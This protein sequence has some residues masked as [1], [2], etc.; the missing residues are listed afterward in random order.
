[1]NYLPIK[2]LYIELTHSCNQHCNHCYLDGGLHHDITEMT[3][4][5][6]K[7]IIKEFKDQGGRYLIIT[8]GEPIM[9]NDIFEI[10]YYIEELEIPFS[11]ASNSL[12]MNESRLRKLSSYKNLDTYFTSLLGVNATEHQAIAGKDSFD[13]VMHAIE[14]MDRKGI[15]TYVQITL[16]K[17]YQKEIENIANLLLPFQHCMMKFTPIGTLGIKS[18]K[19]KSENEKLLV[20]RDSFAEFH[21][22]ITLLQEQYPN[23]IDNP[24]IQNYQ[25]IKEI[26]ADYENEELYTLNYGFLA[27][28]PN[29]DMSFSCDMGN[30]YVFGKAYE[31]IQIPIDQKLKDYIEVLRKAEKNT[32][33][34][35][36]KGILEIDVSVDQYIINDVYLHIPKYEELDYRKNLMLQPD[37]MEYN[38]GC[39]INHEGY[40]SVTGCIQFL[41]EDMSN[42]YQTWIN[43]TSHP[44]NYYYAYIVRKYDEV[45]LGEVN[46]HKNQKKDWYEMGVV[47][48]A[49]YR[50]LGY[51]KEALRQLL[52]VAFEKLNARA[53]HNCFEETRVAALRLHE[54]VGF[55]RVT[56]ENGMVDLLITR[57]QFFLS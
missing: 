43:Q 56:Q 36:K 21:K 3:T 48:E 6:I 27:I 10:L 35:A 34:D 16:A 55:K 8:G 22:R 18:D 54:A 12:G 52:E 7:E 40:D 25:Q 57:E 47:I 32:L 29:G 5:Q 11:F 17:D 9:R 20:P 4:D 13:K 51:S 23:R 2:T 49:K 15:T 24:N 33:E 31:S 1:M 28:R 38:K 39:N 19:E 50:G 44:S 53:V 41:D 46:L 37:T 30:P 14:Y 26:I 42:W 45:F